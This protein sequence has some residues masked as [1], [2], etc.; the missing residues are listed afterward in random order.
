MGNGE[1]RGQIRGGRGTGK[2]VG[3]AIGE[4]ADLV[5]EWLESKEGSTGGH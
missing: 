5:M 1:G 3:G 2:R 4:G